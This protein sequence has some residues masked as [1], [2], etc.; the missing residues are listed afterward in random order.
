ME[1]EKDMENFVQQYGTGNEIPNPP[2]FVNYQATDA[3]PSAS[4]RPTSRPANFIRSSSR[5]HPPRQISIPPEE[6]PVVNTAGVGAGG[7]QKRADTYPD[8]SDALSRQP[9]RSTSA[10]NAQAQQAPY[11]NGNGR[12]S[13]PVLNTSTPPAAASQPINRRQSLASPQQQQQQLQRVLQDPYAEPID[14]AAETYIKVGNNAYKVDLSRDPQQQT[15]S[16]S[17]NRYNAASPT[18][19]NGQ[20]GAAGGQQ[21]PVDPLMRQLEELKNA[22]STSGSVRR[23]TMNTRSKP[24]A[25][26]E[27]KPGHLSTP[28]AS[29]TLTNG[30]GAGPSLLPPGAASDINVAPYPGSH[31]RSPSPARDYRNSAEIVV[32]A[33]PSVSRPTSP[34]PPTAAFMQPKSAPPPSGSEVVQEVLA[35]YQQ[36]LPGERKSISRSNSTSRGHVSNMSQASLSGQNLARPPSQ[37]GHAGIGAYG[38]RSNSPQPISRGP[39]PAPSQAPSQ[40]L[41]QA[42]TNFIQPPAQIGQNMARTPSPNSVGI[43]LD[44]SGRVLHDDMAQK[45]QQQQ[46]QQQRRPSIQTQQ[47]AYQAPPP[48]QQVAPQQQQGQRRNSFVSPAVAPNMMAP[49][50]APQAY[51]VTPPPGMYHQTPSPQPSYIQPPPIQAVYNPPPVQYQ[52]PPPPQQQPMLQ[53]QQQQPAQMG[54]GSVNSVNGLNRGGSMS[55]YGNQTPPQQQQIQPVQQIQPIQQQQQRQMLTVQT[56]PQQT[57]PQ[58]PVYQQPQQHQS[59]YLYRDP[60]PAQRSPSPQPPPQATDDGNN[61]LFYGSY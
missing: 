41:S 7:G 10:L 22:V 4:A 27:P 59:Q 25:S 40:A 50:V 47:P 56:Q 9:T 30:G 42:R 43:A 39:S 14:P 52:A 5:E 48:P 61:V 20:T 35:D 18:K 23:N 16:S 13:H 46:Q 21:G 44:P 55:Y 60:S 54:Y 53:Q 2:T 8:A 29:R 31:S 36:S 19:L 38:S 11:T 24:S 34:N 17:S 58:Q 6:E 45:F 37:M 49:P 57:Q 15:P 28:S 3:I 12:S 1:P 33:H 26:P 51:G 32:G